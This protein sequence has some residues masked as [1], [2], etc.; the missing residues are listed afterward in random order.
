MLHLKDTLFVCSP[1][2]AFVSASEEDV[3]FEVARELNILT[4]KNVGCLL[5]SQNFWAL[6]S[7]LAPSSVLVLLKGKLSPF[8]VG[9]TSTF[10]HTSQRPVNPAD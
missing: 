2:L 7:N 5:L 3:Q 1:L 6:M 9:S 10:G 4:S 8:R